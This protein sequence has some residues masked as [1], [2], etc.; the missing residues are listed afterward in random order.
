[1][2]TRVF[3]LIQAKVGKSNEV[4]AIL[5]GIEGVTTAEQVTGPYDVIA[6]VD[7][8]NLDEIGSIITEKI[9]PIPSVSRIVSCI[10]LNEAIKK[11]R[12]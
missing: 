6:V 3:V 2:S 9:Q 12:M 1:M 8:N 7:G 11:E 10:A 4:V 5:K